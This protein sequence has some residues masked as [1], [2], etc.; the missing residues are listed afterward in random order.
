MAHQITL[1]KKVTRKLVFYLVVIFL[2][3]LG[4]TSYFINEQMHDEMSKKA[5]F[6]LRYNAQALAKPMWDIDETQIDKII[7]NIAEED[8]IVRAVLKDDDEKI[9]KQAGDATKG[10][11]HHHATEFIDTDGIEYRS[12]DIKY[13]YKDKEVGVGELEIYIDTGQVHK[14]IISYVIK[15]IALS[16]LFLV[17]L[18]LVINRTIILSIAPVRNLSHHLGQIDQSSEQEIA[19]VNSDVI[20]V[21]EL[22]SALVRMKTHYTEYQEDLEEQ[23]TERTR[24][25]NDYKTHL[26]QMVEDQVKDVKIAKEEAEK[27]NHAKS[28][29]LANMSHELRTPMHA[30]ISYSSM[31]MEKA[32]SAEKEKLKK[33]YE[34]INKS[35]KRLLG[36]LNDLLD[37]SKLEAGRMV[38][39]IEPLII[40]NTVDDVIS[41]LESLLR[42]KS[43]LIDQKVETENLICNYDRVR[44]SQVIINLLSNAIKFS[45]PGKI[46]TI[47]FHD[48]KVYS[49]EGELDGLQVSIEDKGV[50]IPEDELEKVFDKFVQSSKT[51]TAAGGTGLGLAIS[52]E[53]IHAHKGNIWAENNQNGGATF[54][55]V[56][57]R[58]AINIS[59][60]INTIKM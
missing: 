42:S 19:P 7:E 36:L 57:P 11:E 24:E 55:F 29:F 22:Y 3:S 40:R 34:N 5:S 50:G 45:E 46:I 18:I 23:V 6:I 35:G 47:R 52:K 1:S 9:I 33:Y 26:E 32:D 30:I 12:K 16:S 56:I 27:A 8:F 28:E 48:K 49:D 4:I 13:G 41:E 38:L 2:I 58:G 10:V 51:K 59:N 43:L 20:E 17:A 25:L 53:I 44:I 60:T 14:F 39:D 54:S 37:L 15:T 31:G 21:N